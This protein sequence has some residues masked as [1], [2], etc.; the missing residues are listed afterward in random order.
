MQFDFPDPNTH[1]ERRSLTTTP[2]QKLFALNSPWMLKQ[3]EQLAKK[4]VALDVSRVEDRIQR[5][6]TSVYSRQPEHDELQMGM[7]FLKDGGDQLR[8]WTKYVQV[9]LASNELL[10]AD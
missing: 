7:D 6:Y 5:V 4:M 8:Q 1:S 9:L 2:I 3:S 10:I